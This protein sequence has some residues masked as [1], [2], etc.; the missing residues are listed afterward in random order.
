M[1]KFLKLEEVYS[2][3]QNKGYLIHQEAINPKRVNS[4]IQIADE[5]LD[6]AK[7]DLVKKRFN[8]AYNSYYN[9][10]HGLVEAFLCFDE[11]KSKNH[12]CLFAYLCHKHPELELNWDFFEKIRT[13]R[14]GI[15]Y[16]GNPVDLKDWKD[17]EITFNL[18]IKLLR[19]KIKELI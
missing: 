3:C 11:I 15:N 17:V 8:S 2:S 9:V 13:K 1:P 4:M 10:L 6:S 16:Y 7:D 18:Y 12:Q 19:E 5:T 14:N